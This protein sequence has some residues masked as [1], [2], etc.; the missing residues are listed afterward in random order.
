MSESKRPER[1]ERILSDDTFEQFL[2]SVGL[3]LRLRK[4]PQGE[5]FGNWIIQ[6][7]NDDLEVSMVSDRGHQSV[8]I[9]D[10]NTLRPYGILPPA[11]AVYDVPLI[12]E[13]LF[14]IG[15]K[16]LE[17][18]D[19]KVFVHANWD[20]IVAMF[21]PESREAT[22]QRLSFLGRERVKRTLNPWPPVILDF[23]RF[24]QSIGLTC[25]AREAPDG[26]LGERLMQYNS[27]TVCVKVA[28]KGGW[29]LTIAD[30]I[31][32][33]DTWY[34]IRTIRR[35]LLGDVESKLPFLEWFAFARA[36][37]EAVV[38]I[39]RPAEREETHRRLRPLEEE[40][41]RRLQLHRDQQTA[42]VEQITKLLGQL[43]K[44]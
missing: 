18:F 10:K 41:R 43:P 38:A 21:S 39:F 22:H 13:L 5:P 19:Q 24:L 23:E 31:S 44:Q 16:R 11:P 3:T 28:S 33:P 30:R 42:Q 1:P 12:S 25:E 35:M 37:W 29:Q 27:E 32:H 40:T 4:G 6:F 9:S 34:D 36:N 20:A 7:G 26:A 17:F 8:T 2:L 15:P 14:G